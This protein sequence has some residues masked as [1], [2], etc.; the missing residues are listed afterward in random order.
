[1]YFPLTHCSCFVFSN[2]GFWCGGRNFAFNQVQFTITK[3][4]GVGSEEGCGAG[5]RAVNKAGS[6]AGSG[7]R[8]GAGIE[9]RRGAV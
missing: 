7:A 8:S 1:M 9:E 4:N 2:I 5:S 6:G 3:R